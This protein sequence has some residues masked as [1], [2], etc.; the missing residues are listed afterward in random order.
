M[1][2]AK[3]I[4]TVVVLFGLL[5]AISGCGESK[6][7]TVP[8]VKG[9]DPVTAYAVLHRAGLRVSIDT[10]L[11]FNE[12]MEARSTTPAESSVARGSTISLEVVSGYGFPGRHIGY[13]PSACKH[14]PETA[15]NLIGKSLSAALHLDVNCLVVDFTEV[16]PLR[17]G[18]GPQLF[19]NY[20]VSQQSPAA[21]VR[22]L[23]ISASHPPPQT[24]TVQVTAA[25]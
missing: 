25:K 21:E 11:R 19:D 6:K 20:V 23:P 4:S 22:F 10:A 14:A 17:D 24:I 5:F 15:P 18:S 13:E 9:M 2:Q 1:N 7:V 3:R 16:P 12:S 8:D